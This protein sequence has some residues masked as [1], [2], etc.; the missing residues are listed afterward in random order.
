MFKDK[1]KFRQPHLTAKKFFADWRDEN[2]VRKRKAFL[3]ASAAKAHQFHMQGIIRRKKAQAK[4]GPATS[5][6]R[7][8]KARTAHARK[9]HTSSA[10]QS[11]ISRRSKSKKRTSP[12]SP[13]RGER[14]THN[15]PSTSTS[16]NSNKSSNSSAAPTSPK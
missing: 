1:R 7:G 8:Q 10:K 12:H 5:S 11:A 2:G 16:G 15:Q 6:R 13:K 14:T 9:S 3:T 4:A